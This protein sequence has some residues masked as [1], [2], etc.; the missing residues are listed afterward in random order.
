MGSYT[1]TAAYARPTQA[2]HEM[3]PTAPEMIEGL[4]SIFISNSA[5]SDSKARDVTQGDAHG[6]MLVW[7]SYLS[8]Q[9]RPITRLFAPY[10]GLQNKA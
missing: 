5:A 4:P 7:D 9:S 3:S 10:Q 1:T 2:S 8:S 6:S